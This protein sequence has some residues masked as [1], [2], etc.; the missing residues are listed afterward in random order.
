M[1]HAVSAG[2]ACTTIVLVE[3]AKIRSVH[4]SPFHGPPILMV[5][6]N[7]AILSFN[8]VVYMSLH[9]MQVDD[10]ELVVA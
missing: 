5:D 9:A 10:R 8:I 7:A 2:Y 1:A 6:A 4:D 3:D